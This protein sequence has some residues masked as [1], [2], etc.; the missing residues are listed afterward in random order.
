MTLMR[1]SSGLKPIT[2]MAVL[3]L[4]LGLNLML[5]HPAEAVLVSYWA[6]ENNTNDSAG[7]NHGTVAGTVNYSVGQFGQAFAL[8]KTGHIDVANP[9]A[10]G[11]ES[12]TG[13]TV[14]A[15]IFRD[16]VGIPWGTAPVANLRT[17]AN[18]SGFTLEEVYQQPNTIGFI[19]NTT[20]DQNVTY[21]THGVTASG[22]DFGTFYHIAATFDAATHSI[23]LYRDGEVVA[24][25]DDMLGTEM[26]ANPASEFQIGR[27]IVNGSLWDGRIDEMRFYNRPLSQSE[28]QNV[29]A[30]P[31]PSILL[32][33]VVG[34]G[35][36]LAQRRRRGNTRL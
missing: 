22:W 27:N 8:A 35:G 25:R 9:V 26:I 19:V 33:F 11:L 7:S 17:T 15:W 34:F 24:S 14:A 13:F 12:V 3:G 23:V 1:T 30:I 10:G 18:T 28:I 6:A 29:M 36:L 31:E 5:C 4:A 32:L 2:V 20:G 16:G 21:A